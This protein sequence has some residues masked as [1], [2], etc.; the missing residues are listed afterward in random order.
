MLHAVRALGPV[1]PLG[2]VFT[3]ANVQP[4]DAQTTANVYVQVEGRA[5]AVYGYNSTS[6]GKLS[7]IPGSPFR[8]GTRIIGGNGSQFLTLGNTLIH[9]YRVASNGAIGSQLSQVPVFDYAGSVCAG[10]PSPVPAGLC[11][12]IPGDRSMCC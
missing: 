11:S 2:L 8:P 9:S 3:F 5:G 4:L 12:I 10:T 1:V 7:A 6:D